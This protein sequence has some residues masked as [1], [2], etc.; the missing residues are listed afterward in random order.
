MLTAL[1]PLLAGFLFA[2]LFAV[3]AFAQDD[4][5]WEIGARALV[6][7]CQE[8]EK[9]MSHDSDNDKIVPGGAIAQ[10]W[11]ASCEGSDQEAVRIVCLAVVSDNSPAKCFLR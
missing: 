1:R 5:R 8:N 4:P 3:S 2:P 9:I 7:D 10:T 11:Y 6:T